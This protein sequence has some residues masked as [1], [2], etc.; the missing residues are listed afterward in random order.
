M[1]DPLKGIGVI[2][3]FGMEAHFRSLLHTRVSD[4][5][6]VKVK[7]T[8][9][10]ELD[11]MHCGPEEK[12]TQNKKPSNHSLSHKRVS[13]A[14]ERVNGPASG[15]ALQSVFVVVLAHCARETCD[16]HKE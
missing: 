6:K 1:L 2:R 3:A 11:A 15:P 4:N 5:L 7:L 9:C 16:L 13:G 12:T 10:I 8:Q 14:S